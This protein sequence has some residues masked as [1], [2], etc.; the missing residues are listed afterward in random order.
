[1]AVT[2]KLKGMVEQLTHD[3]VEVGEQVRR[4]LPLSMPDHDP[5]DRHRGRAR[6]VSRAQPN[7]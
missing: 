5:P 7:T 2:D 1:M 4:P 6:L 3:L